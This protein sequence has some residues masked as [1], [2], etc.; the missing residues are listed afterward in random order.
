M[1]PPATPRESAVSSPSAAGRADAGTSQTRYRIPSFLLAACGCF[2]YWSALPPWNLAHLVWPAPVPWIAL[3]LR[4]TRNRREYLGFWAASFLFWLATLHWLRF[5]HWA[6]ALGGVFLSAYLACYLPAFIALLRVAIDRTRIPTPLAAGVLW[7]ALDVVRAY[8]LTGFSMGALPHAL[9]RQPLW[10]Q[11]ADLVGEQGLGGIIV[12]LAAGLTLGL[13]PGVPARRRIGLLAATAGGF[14]LLAAYGVAR[15]T[16][17]EKA[18]VGPAYRIALIQGSADIVLDP[19][20]GRRL[21][22]HREYMTLTAEA[23]SRSPKPDLVIWPET[24]YGDFLYDFGDDLT[25]PREWNEPAESFPERIRGFKRSSLRGLTRFGE[26]AGT[27]L[28]LG[29]ETVYVDGGRMRFFNSA[30]FVRHDANGSATYVGRYDKRHLVLFGEY[31]PFVEYLPWLQDF[32]PLSTSTTP[33]LHA[34]AFDVPGPASGNEPSPSLRIAPNICYESVLSRVIRNQLA[35]L[36]SK[37]Q[38]PDVLVNLTNDG[39][40]FGSSELDLHL[41]CGI[42]RAV[43]T[44]KPFLV[45]ANTGISAAVTPSGRILAEGPRR[46]PKVVEV[47]I[48]R[49]TSRSL[50]AT[51]GWVGSLI[52]VVVAFGTGILGFFPSKKGGDLPSEKE[53]RS[54]I[55][56]GRADP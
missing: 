15:T 50:Y 5:P 53:I 54:S 33:G 19:P 29:L 2:L 8:L 1:T 43:E 40:F 3:A 27:S 26:Q 46:A 28:L 49:N 45:A 34:K 24:V 9:Y 10:I 30:A 38:E 11:A 32:S 18:D 23:V 17:V 44:R 31:I 55:T 4:R 51:F 48:R 36:R 6:T 39:W 47:S 56:D 35:E 7:T 22:I 25:P 21:E 16:A 37:N 20:P 14:A 42:F 41:A 12:A 13:R 52:C